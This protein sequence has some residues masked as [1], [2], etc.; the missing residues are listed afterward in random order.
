VEGELTS[1]TGGGL[2]LIVEN[3]TASCMQ[4]SADDWFAIAKWGSEKGLLETWQKGIAATLASYAND[5]WSK[6]PSEKQAKHGVAII[7]AYRE[8]LSGSN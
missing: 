3:D 1:V 8:S 2:S 5:N 7:K 6:K 4:L